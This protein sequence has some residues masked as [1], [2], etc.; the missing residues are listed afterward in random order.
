M[1]NIIITVTD[2]NEYFKIGSSTHDTINYI[3]H[4]S[5]TIIYYEFRINGKN[6]Q[7]LGMCSDF[8]TSKKELII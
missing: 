5:I 1:D 2:N 3:F 4:I 8:R 6:I 7:E